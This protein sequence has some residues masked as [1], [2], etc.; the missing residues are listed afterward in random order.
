MAQGFQRHQRVAGQIKREIAELIRDSGV[1]SGP[2]A[3]LTMLT[4]TDCEVSRDLAHAKIFYSVLNADEQPVAEQWLGEAAGY[5]RGELGHRMR[6]RIV[7][8]LT[9]VF[10]NSIE[11]GMQM[12]ALIRAVREQDGDVDEDSESDDSSES[13]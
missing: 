11:Q 6:L 1:D 10:D 13:R 2:N 3:P 7:P 9:F 8:Q 5:L 12:D 4:I